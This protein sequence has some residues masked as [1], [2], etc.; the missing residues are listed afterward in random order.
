[1]IRRY[2]DRRRVLEKITRRSGS[3]QRENFSYEEGRLSRRTLRSGGERRQWTYSYDGEGNLHRRRTYVN[4]GMHTS[5]E[6]REG[7]L[8]VVTV[9]RDGEPAVRLRYEGEELKEKHSL[10]DGT[11]EG[12]GE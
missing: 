4:G 9:Y 2:D 5:T 3:V 10:P 11:D 8:R 1:V 12:R 6:Y 7:S